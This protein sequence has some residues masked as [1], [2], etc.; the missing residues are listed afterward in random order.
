MS[1][2]SRDERMVGYCFRKIIFQILQSTESYDLYPTHSGFSAVWN[3]SRIAQERQA[4]SKRL[5]AI[6]LDIAMFA[7]G[8]NTAYNFGIN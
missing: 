3:A 7:N 5:L 2:H 6:A 1:R 4:M 8:A